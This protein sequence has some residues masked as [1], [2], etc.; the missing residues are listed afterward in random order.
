M[1]KNKNDI[2][3][4]YIKHVIVSVM[5]KFSSE[6]YEDIYS[7]KREVEELREENAMLLEMYSNGKPSNS[8][9]ESKTDI[10][11]KYGIGEMVDNEVEEEEQEARPSPPPNPHLKENI[12]IQYM[13]KAGI[14]TDDLFHDED[15][16]VDNEGNP[17]MVE[18]KE[19]KD[20]PEIAEFLN[21]DYSKFLEDK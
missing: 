5:K 19:E 11:E 15:F 12:A 21:R 10:A 17:V 13:K 9:K 7:M 14:D 8:I 20:S 3:K 16:E 6:I 2:L 1:K 4:E 18:K